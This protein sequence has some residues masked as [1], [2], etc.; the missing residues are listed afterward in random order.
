MVIAWIRQEMETTFASASP[1][2][3]GLTV[4][5][6][7]LSKAAWPTT[8]TAPAAQ[9]KME[10]GCPTNVFA[11]NIGKEPFVKSLD[12]QKEG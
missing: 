9:M 11:T 2:G 5:C 8:Y 10:R 1:D 4:T 7:R 3:K 6:A 12:A